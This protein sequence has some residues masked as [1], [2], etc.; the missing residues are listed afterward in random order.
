MNIIYKEIDSEIEASIVQTFG[1]WVK[2]F[3]CIHYGEGCYSVAG[4]A[5]GRPVGFISTYVRNYPEP[6]SEFTEAFIDVIEVDASYRRRGIA[7]KLLSLTE[8]WAKRCGYHQIS[9]WSSDD[10][11]EAIR[12]WYALDYCVSPAVMRG[13]SL[14]EE[15]QGEK[16]PGFYVA[17]MLNPFGRRKA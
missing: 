8:D 4:L 15:F 14:L 11:T 5:D 6:L 9:S 2:E 10:K 13:E 7:S 12:M 17:K 16:I 3:E 1:G